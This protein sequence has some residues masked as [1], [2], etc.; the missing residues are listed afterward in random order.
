[1]GAARIA[2]ALGIQLAGH[3]HRAARDPISPPLA[4]PFDA[5]ARAESFCVTVTLPP[6]AGGEEDAPALAGNAGGLGEALRIAGQRIDIAAV[7]LQLRLGGLDDAGG[8]GFRIAAA[9]L[10]HELAVRERAS[11]TSTS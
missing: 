2:L 8:L 6:I 11:R 9:H 10:H 1:M 4:L 5:A 3:L 7:R